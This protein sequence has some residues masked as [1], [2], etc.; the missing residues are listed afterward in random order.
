MYYFQS[1]IG[2]L[3]VGLVTWKWDGEMYE[4]ESGVGNLRL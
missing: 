3:K 4:F 2:H 1:G